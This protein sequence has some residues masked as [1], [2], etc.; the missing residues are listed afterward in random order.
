MTGFGWAADLRRNSSTLCA[1][2]PVQS[3]TVRLA[4]GC[5]CYEKNYYHLSPQTPHKS[6]D[7]FTAESEYSR[8][9]FDFS[10][11]SDKAALI[12]STGPA[13]PSSYPK[14]MVCL[15]FSEQ[16]MR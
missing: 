3:C 15:G 12:S 4:E 11:F 10:H 13:S 1:E 14:A 6:Q 9:G 16:A 2:I 5:E 7:G 8:F